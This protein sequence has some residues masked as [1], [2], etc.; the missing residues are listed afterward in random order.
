MSGFLQVGQL[1][2][3]LTVKDSALNT[4]VCTVHDGAIQVDGAG[5]VVPQTDATGSLA[6][7]Y[8]LIGPLKQWGN[9][10]TWPAVDAFHM[11]W[12]N[13]LGPQQGFTIPG[14]VGPGVWQDKWNTALDTGSG[15][16]VAMTNG[17]NTVVGT[18]THCTTTMC[19]GPGSPTVPQTSMS[20]ILWPT[21]PITGGGGGTSRSYNPVDFMHRRY[22]SNGSLQLG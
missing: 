19:L 12:A 17:T 21:Y 2:F 1:N 10:P 8:K 7:I 3:Q 5:M 13:T 15:G 22:A 11:T 9:N 18:N 16:T 20:F 14:Q 4:S 6:K